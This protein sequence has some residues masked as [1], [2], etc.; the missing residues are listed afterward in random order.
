[1][2]NKAGRGSPEEISLYY[3]LVFQH[4]TEGLV[5]HAVIYDDT[6]TAIDYRLTETI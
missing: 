1:M 6:G 5:S 4:V 2:T 3:Q